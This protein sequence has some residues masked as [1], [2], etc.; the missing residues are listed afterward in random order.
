MFYLR[1]YQVHY[2]EYILQILLDK[3]AFWSGYLKN[4]L[5]HANSLWVMTS[6]Y[7]VQPSTFKSF[8]RPIQDTLKKYRDNFQK[9]L[10]ILLSV[11]V[12]QNESKRIFGFLLLILM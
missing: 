3:K 5:L 7:K 1:K 4:D 12:S 10:K 11:N 9:K 8:T 6:K 2:I